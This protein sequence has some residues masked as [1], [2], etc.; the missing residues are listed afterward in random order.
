MDFKTLIIAI[1][2]GEISDDELFKVRN[3]VYYE[4]RKRANTMAL[5]HEEIAYYGAAYTQCLEEL[6]EHY[7]SEWEREYNPER[8]GILYDAENA[9]NDHRSVVEL[10]IEAVMECEDAA[11]RIADEL[12]V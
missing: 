4:M 7:H 9:I 1:E 5:L 10:V 2:N 3:A 6:A 8:E 12:N 11:E